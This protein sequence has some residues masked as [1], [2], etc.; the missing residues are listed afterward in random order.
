M[1][2][3]RKREIANNYVSEFL[4]KEIVNEYLNNSS[5]DLRTWIRVKGEE[6]ERRSRDN[7]RNINTTK[8]H[9]CISKQLRILLP[10]GIISDLQE[11]KKRE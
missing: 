5:K 9:I 1:D 3:K 6:S 8:C 2:A 10:E 7:L 4:A 11:L